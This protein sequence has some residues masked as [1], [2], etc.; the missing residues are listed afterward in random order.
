MKEKKL[1][2]VFSPETGQNYLEYQEDG[3]TIKIW[4]EDETSIKARME[5]IK[6]YDLAGVASWR[7]GYETPEVWSL[8]DSYLAGP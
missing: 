8:I 6:K 4:L 7:R 3:K 2:P 1:T 5:L